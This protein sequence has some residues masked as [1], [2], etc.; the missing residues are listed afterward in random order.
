[1][2]G[3]AYVLDAEFH[4]HEQHKNNE[5][6]T[7]FSNAVEKIAILEQIKIKACARTREHSPPPPAAPLIL[8]PH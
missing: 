4:G 3:A 8:V 6:M 1:V 2:R 5:V 7:S